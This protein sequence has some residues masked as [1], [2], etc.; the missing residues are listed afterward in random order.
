MLDLRFQIINALN[1]CNSYDLFAKCLG[2]R[3]QIW[4]LVTLRRSKPL[5]L[6]KIQ[7]MLQKMN[8]Q[9]LK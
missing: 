8:S 4:T 6:L 7:A 3:I 1:K 9:L 2:Y 5:S